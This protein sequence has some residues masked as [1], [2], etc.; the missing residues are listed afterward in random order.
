[1]RQ[2]EITVR[3]TEKIEEAIAKLEKRGFKR[4]RESDIHDIYMSNL[5]EE[6]KRE[7]YNSNNLFKKNKHSKIL[8]TFS[9]IKKF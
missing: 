5:D 1:M 8:E 4:I 7:K 3:L 9:I 6:I 2:I